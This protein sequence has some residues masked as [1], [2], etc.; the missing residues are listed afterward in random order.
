M[1]EQANVVIE[2]WSEDHLD[3]LRRLNAPEMTEHLGGPETEAQVADRHERYLRIAG[4]G[5]GR[6]FAIVLLPAREPV[7]SVGYWDRTWAGEQVHEMGWGILP[8]YQG[9]GFATAAVSQAIA[10]A[11]AEGIHRAI[12]AYPGTDNPAS[13]AVCRKLGFTLIGECEFE[14]PPGSMMRCNDWR[15]EL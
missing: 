9:R 7:G 11:R 6:M 12:H 1:K 2:S 3:L 5:T 15:L 13:N 8:A 4:K 10:S 14:Y